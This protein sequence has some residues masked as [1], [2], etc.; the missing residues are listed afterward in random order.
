M[1]RQ[2]Y[3]HPATRQD[4]WLIE[5]MGPRVLSHGG[6]FVEIGAHD[7][8]RHSNTLMLERE[9]G[10][11]GR[12]VEANPCLYVECKKNRLAR[13]IQLCV[14]P[15]CAQDQ[16]FIVGDAY[17]GLTAH[18]P[19]EWLVKHAARNNRTI[20]VPTMSLSRLF[21]VYT[22]EHPI[23]YLSL[24]VEGAELPILESF[25]RNPTRTI[26]YLTVEFRYDHA[27]LRELEVL[28]ADQFVLDQVRGFD[29]CFINKEIGALNVPRSRAA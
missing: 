11:D 23:D 17:S 28:L 14:G 3:S 9:F 10:W 26:R 19:T 24:D 18:M 21:Q 1:K 6:F 16:A 27:L 29:A 20:H 22:P 5:K 8:L 12:L 13:S 2:F 7:G 25:M 4:E 15:K